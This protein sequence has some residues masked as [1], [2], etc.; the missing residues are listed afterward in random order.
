MGSVEKWIWRYESD[1]AGPEHVC[2]VEVEDYPTLPQVTPPD[3]YVIHKPL[4][5]GGDR[6]MGSLVLISGDGPDPG[7]VFRI[8]QPQRRHGR[9]KV[10]NR[11][12]G[13]LHWE[14]LD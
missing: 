2:D 14:R 5:T 8:L 10:G 3:D 12:E 11:T 4:P 13:P 1:P 6:P 9:M 7:R